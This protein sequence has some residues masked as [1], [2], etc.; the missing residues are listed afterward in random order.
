[1]LVETNRRRFLA[2]AAGLAGS[3]RPQL[4]R[5]ERRGAAQ[6]VLVVGGGL[7]GL[8]SAY[9]GCAESLLVAAGEQEDLRPIFADASQAATCR[10]RHRQGPEKTRRK[11]PSAARSEVGLPSGSGGN[12]CNHE[13][14]SIAPSASRAW[15]V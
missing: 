3:A 13:D 9:L 14:P 7:A 10:M 6:R 5:P 8:C 11:F 4:T 12:H 1:M 2:L 15:T